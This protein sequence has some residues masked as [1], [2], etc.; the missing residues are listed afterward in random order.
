VNGERYLTY[1]EIIFFMSSTT[2][3]NNLHVVIVD[4]DAIGAMTQREFIEAAGHAVIAILGDNAALV[5]FLDE[6]FN[7][8]RGGHD[9]N[10]YVFLLDGS[11]I[12]D[13]LGND[14]GNYSQEIITQK[15]AGTRFKYI[16]VGR[17][18]RG[19]IIGADMQ[20]PKREVRNS[21][22]IKRLEA[23]NWNEDS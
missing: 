4:D 17:P 18:T 16:T 15:L 19:V 2:L 10:P 3:E 7:E 11:H 9:D 14:H 5:R 22:M 8:E 12:E 13:M 20:M 23:L 6:E 1:Y 21:E